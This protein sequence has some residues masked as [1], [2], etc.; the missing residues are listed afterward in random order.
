MVDTEGAILIAGR[1][2]DW[3]GGSRTLTP[4][5]ATRE[6]N[7]ALWF[8]AGLDG[9]D[10]QVW[11]R[12]DEQSIGRLPDKTPEA[13]GRRL[14]DALLAWVSKSDLPLGSALHRLRSAS[15]R[16]ATRGSNACG[17]ER[18]LTARWW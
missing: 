2:D 14:V 1:R 8:G 18:P 3:P 16:A 5:K 7:G 12:I 4:R 15:L 9:A 13:R 10:A 6:P 11:F 17:G